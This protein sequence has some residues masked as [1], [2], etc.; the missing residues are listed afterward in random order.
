MDFNTF[1]SDVSSGIISAIVYGLLTYFIGIRP[2]SKKITE[3]TNK[4]VD[5][6]SSA[7]STINEAY[8]KKIENIRIKISKIEESISAIESDTVVYRTEEEYYMNVASIDPLKSE[9]KELYLDLDTTIDKFLEKI[10]RCSN[11]QNS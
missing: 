4:S 5:Y 2:L 1:W 11:N 6:K 3:L 10:D 9:L 7:L 8:N